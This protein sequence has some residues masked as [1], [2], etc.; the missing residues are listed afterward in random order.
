MAPEQIPDPWTSFF[1]EIDAALNQEG[2]LHCLGGF[3]AKTLYALPCET[4]DVD[5]L[6]L[7][8]NP[9]IDSVINAAREGSELHRKYGVYLQVVG[10]APTPEA[11]ES[12]LTEMFPGTFKCLRL[13]ALDPYDPALTKIERNSQRDRDDANHLARMVP[14]DLEILR[15]RFAEELSLI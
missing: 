2:V 11:Y 3:V 15:N 7:A 10:L 14:F 6:P 12:R 1:N 13:F 8:S 9:E 4:A 5:V